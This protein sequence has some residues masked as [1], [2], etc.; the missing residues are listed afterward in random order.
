MNMD[1]KNN[2]TCKT[3]KI[4]LFDNCLSEAK[5]KFYKEC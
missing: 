2:I 3:F 5:C 1:I 4:N